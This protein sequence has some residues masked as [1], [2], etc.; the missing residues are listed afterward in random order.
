M[1]ANIRVLI[2]ADLSPFLEIDSDLNSQEGLDL[3]IARDGLHAWELV[4]QQR[5]DL[6]FMDLHT[7]V[8]SGDEC[9]L[10]IRQNPDFLDL[11]VVLVIDGKDKDDL[12]RC[13]HAGCSDIVFKPLTDHL[14]LATSRRLLG[15][16]YRS[17]P[18]VSTRVIVRYGCDP[19]SLLHG[20]S[21]NLSSG[22][23]FIETA[24]PY[25][26]DQELF[27]EF[28]LPTAEHPIACKAFVAWNN[29]AE[30][31]VNIN[32]PQ[33]MGLQ[34]LSLSLPDLLCIWG[35]IARQENSEATRLCP[36]SGW[37]PLS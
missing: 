29:L 35:H 20:F 28:C 6:V 2:T 36:L 18:R 27:L 30:N 25:P 21:F 12:A 33:G 17:F 11:P 10:R 16:A 15:L 37:K 22:G 31:P 34:F 8:L 19:D 24:S 5:P 32:M 23:M 4:R 14:L 13:L 26:I 9:C 7:P 3:L 1:A